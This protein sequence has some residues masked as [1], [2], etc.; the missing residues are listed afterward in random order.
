MDQHK[1][2]SPGAMAYRPPVVSGSEDWRPRTGI[3][4]RSPAQ[5]MRPMQTTQSKQMNSRMEQSPVKPDDCTGVL[6]CSAPLA[7]PYVPFQRENPARYQ[8]QRALSRGTLFPGLDLPLMGMVNG[9]KTMTPLTKLMSLQFA[10]K[11]LGL[12]LDTHPDDKEALA[13][14]RDYAN[15]TSEAKAAYEAK[16]GP[17]MMKDAGCGDCWDWVCDPWPWDYCQEG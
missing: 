17:L 14:F 10:V 11:E 8:T 1:R 4:Y 6:P 16:H 15:R 12:Y 5:S 9:D 3:A 13:L 7:N 2:H